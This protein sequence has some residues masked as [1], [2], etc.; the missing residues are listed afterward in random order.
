MHAAHVGEDGITCADC[1]PDVNA[2]HA[3]TAPDA[4]VDG[5]VT[6]AA[7]EI[8]WDSATATCTVTCHG[9]AHA[10]DPWMGGGHHPEGYEQGDRHGQDAL[11]TFVEG[12][13]RDCHGA[14]LAGGTAG[15]ACQD[16]HD[17]G[18]TRDCTYCHGGTLD[19]TGAPPEDLDGTTAEPMLTFQS[20][21]AHMD[22]ATHAPY[23]CDQ[24]HGAVSLS[25]VDAL[26]DAGHWFDATVGESEVDFSDGLSPSGSWT[27]AQCNNVYCH[28]SGESSATGDVSDGTGALA[29]DDCHPDATSGSSA[30]DDMSGEHKKHV[31]EERAECYECH[32]DV[33]DSSFALKDE[34]LHVDGAPDVALAA[35]TSMSISA[36]RCTGTCHGDDE[37]HNDPVNW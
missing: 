13:C 35:S 8:G 14:D 10:G 21:H 30:I 6:L 33:V 16:C 17:A 19:A 1:H 5:A 18:W 7:A 28:G 23:D 24:C 22:P 4:H 9:E 36:G 3:I 37:N 12:D 20:H 32:D 11:L 29:C 25:Y 31:I 26:S 27:G 15:V 2:A 34:T